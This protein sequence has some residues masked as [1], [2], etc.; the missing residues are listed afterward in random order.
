MKVFRTFEEVRTLGDACV[1]SIGNF[2]GVHRGHQRLTSAARE[3]ADRRGLPV[4]AVTFDPHP[5]AV[6]AASR[7]PAAL[8][9]LDERLALL[10]RQSV[11]AA[12]VL[13]C[14]ASL[15]TLPAESF[16]TRLTECCRPRVI[17]EGPTFSFG[18]GREGSIATLRQHAPRLGYEVL[19]VEEL[20]LPLESGPTAVNSSTIRVA[21][22]DGRVGDA[23]QMLGRPHRVVGRVGRGAGRGTPLG[24]PTANL[25]HVP[26][27]VPGHAVYAAA[28]QLE[29]G[30]LHLAA[31]NVGPQPTFDSMTARVEA[32]LIDWSGEIRQQR[33]GLHF[34]AALRG[35]TRF[36]GVDAL[37][38]QIARDVEEVRRHAPQVA[39]LAR[40]GLLELFTR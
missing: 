1:A 28:A 22:R 20:R 37:R 2:D 25:E 13:H 6:L 9:T 4:L 21:L 17:V 39:S 3:E 31:V 5:L 23:H 16:L 19:I 38:E 12:L 11:D 14:D 10:A 36:T 15:L 27:L 35:Q 34:L 30:A 18:R 33:L 40:D 8:C 32:H 26:Q 24:F 29:G 7:A